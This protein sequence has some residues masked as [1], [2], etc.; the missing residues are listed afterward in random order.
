LAE[1]N[2]SRSSIGIVD[3]SRVD[4]DG[5]DPWMVTLEEF[6]SRVRLFAS[7]AINVTPNARPT[8]N[9]SHNV[10]DVKAGAREGMVAN[11]TTR[12]A[13]WRI[14][15]A[16][17]AYPRWRRDGKE[18]SYFGADGALMALPVDADRDVRFRV[19]ATRVVPDRSFRDSVSWGP[20][21]TCHRTVNGFS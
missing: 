15:P 6:A 16:A 3:D 7:R 4:A 12:C 21:L 5:D 14:R 10:R 13:K 2:I 1:R 20:K 8:A 18:L 11:L 19:S 17:G 9:G